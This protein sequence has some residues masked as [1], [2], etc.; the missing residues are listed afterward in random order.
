MLNWT[1]ELTTASA[2]LGLIGAWC[3]GYSVID[4]FEG[5]EYGGVTTDG[6]VSRTADYAKWAKTN[7]NR[8]AWGMALITI[9]GVLQVI[10]L[11]LPPPKAPH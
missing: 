8:T 5:R 6:G 9:G 7:D 3:I 4:K 1:R 11:Y 2:A 10:A